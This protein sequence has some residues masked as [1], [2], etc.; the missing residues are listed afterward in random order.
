MAEGSKE[1]TMF[2]IP[3]PQGGQYHFMVMPFGLVNAP[4]AF[5]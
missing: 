2:S 3:G 5:Q 1:Y 4:F